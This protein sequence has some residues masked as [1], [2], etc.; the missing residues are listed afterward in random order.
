MIT[1]EQAYAWMDKQVNAYNVMN[2]ELDF[3]YSSICNLAF[4]RV[5]RIHVY[6]MDILADIVGRPYLRSYL[7]DTSDRLSFHYKGVEFFGYSYDKRIGKKV[8]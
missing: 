1:K 7:D 6:H 4:Y 5:P 8:D 3:G 2:E